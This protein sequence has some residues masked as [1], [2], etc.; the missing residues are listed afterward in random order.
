MSQQ[1]DLFTDNMLVALEEQ[2]PPHNE[3]FPAPTVSQEHYPD[4]QTLLTRQ[5]QEELQLR[6]ALTIRLTV[7]DN[8]STM[9][10]VRHPINGKPVQ[11]RLHRM[12]LS[13]PGDVRKAL[14]HWVKHPR[15]RKFAILFREFIVAHTNEIRNREARELP[16]V[17]RGNCYDLKEAFDELNAQYFDNAINVTISWGRD[18]G[19]STRSIRFGGYYPAE[20]LI[21][22]H[23]RLDQPFV[24]AFLLRYIVYHEMLH[25]HIGIEHTENGRKSIHPKE[26]KRMEKAFPEYDAS[27]AWIEDPGNL[28]RMLRRSRHITPESKKN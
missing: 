9:M 27:I 23:P 7:T 10:S 16:P 21:R 28:R 17:T 6:C 1:L 26:F 25:A 12:F 2:Q 8:T 24:P 22:I 18:C 3:L 15:S 13:A 5:L 14:A 20:Q 19:R 11:V 4:E